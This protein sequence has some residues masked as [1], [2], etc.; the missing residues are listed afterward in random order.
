MALCRACKPNADFS[1]DS[2]PSFWVSFKGRGQEIGQTLG[3]RAFTRGDEK[4]AVYWLAQATEDWQRE[5]RG[6]PP[7]GDSCVSGNMTRSMAIPIGWRRLEPPLHAKMAL[8]SA[9]EGPL[10]PIRAM[11]DE[12]GS[13]CICTSTCTCMCE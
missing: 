11:H 3:E 13:A 7:S 6:W 10:S 1:Y 5:S 4:W 12:Q 9:E 8:V 2:A